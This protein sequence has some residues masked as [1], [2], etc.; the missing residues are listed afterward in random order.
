MINILN[1]I[2]RT[3]GVAVSGGIDS[4]VVYDF[5]SRNHD[6]VPVFFDHGTETSRLALEFLC[7]T[8]PYILTGG[9]TEKKTKKES[10]EE[11]WRNQRYD[12]FHNTCRNLYVVT[13]HHLDDAVET[14]VWS[15]LHGNPKLI[16]YRNRNV[17]RPFLL[18]A[19]EEFVE[20]AERHN[21]TWIEDESNK[22]NSY[23]RNHIRNVMMPH[24]KKV[25]PGIATVIR[26]K[27]IAENS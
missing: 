20:W 18:N 5:L 12:F 24:I 21:V 25:N 8:L 7:D 16:P 22:D 17:I 4:M 10:W 9:L 3:I 19:K 15:A 26:K 27:L 2:P 1:T 6:I 11:Y 13:A 14:W 23:M